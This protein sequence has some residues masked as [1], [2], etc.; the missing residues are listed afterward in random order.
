MVIRSVLIFNVLGESRVSSNLST[1][2]ANAPLVIKNFWSTYRGINAD[3]LQESYHDA[4]GFKQE[5]LSLFNLGYLSLIERSQAEELY[6]ACCSQISA[7]LEDKSDIPDDLASLPQ[8]MA[9][10]YYVNLSI[11]RSIPDSWAIEQLFLIMPIHRLN[12]KPSVKGILADITCDSDGKMDRFINRTPA[13]LKEYRSAYRF[14]GSHKGDSVFPFE[15]VIPRKWDKRRMCRNALARN[16][17]PTFELH[18]IDNTSP[19]YLGLFLAGAY[20]E[21]MG[22]LHNLFGDTNVVQIDLTATGEIIESVVP[23]D[24]I[25]AVLGYLQYDSQD[26]IDTVSQ[27]IEL[28]KQDKRITAAEARK[29]LYNYR[30]TLNSYTYLKI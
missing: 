18:P 7:Q 1:P 8:I 20:Q 27:Q 22:N 12:E 3:N 13:S 5:A 11:F 21:I 14:N 10:T 16:T 19:Y 26:L 15:D 30:S 17:K 23:G 9:S 2:I 29:L 25:K 4:I 24:S 6:W 28:A